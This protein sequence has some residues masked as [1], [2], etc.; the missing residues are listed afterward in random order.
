MAS[1]DTLISN[2]QTFAQGANTAAVGALDQMR[3]DIGNVGFTSIGF[4][5]PVLPD[6]PVFP[7]LLVPPTLDTIA[8][9]LPPDPAAAPVFQ[10][11]GAFDAGVAP[12]LTALVPVLTL[13]SKPADVAAFT[14]SLPGLTTSF[15]FPSAPNLDANSIPVP[16]IA[17]RAVPV[18]PQIVLPVFEAQRPGDLAPAPTDYN[19]QFIAAYQSAQPN[20]VASIEGYLDGVINRFNPNYRAAMT[21]IEAQL[22]KYLAGGTA[23]NPDIENAIYERSRGKGNAEYM[24]TRQVAMDDAARRGYTLPDGVL[25]ATVNAARQSAADNNAMSARDIAVAQAEMEQKNLQFA[26]STSADLRRSVL[27]ASLAYHSNLIQINGQA[28]DY[29]SKILGAIVQIY[30]SAV[31]AYMARADVYRAEATVYEVRLKSALAGIDLYR[32]QIDA[33]VALTRV[34]QSKIDVYK[35]RI[36]VLQSLAAVYRSQIDAVVAQASIEKL[37][38]DIFQAQVQGYA[39]T[40]GAKQAE[41]QGYTAAIGGEQAKQAVFSEQVRAFSANVEAYRSIVAAK[42]AAVSAAATTN[43]ARSRAYSAILSGYAAVVQARGDKARTQLENQRQQVIAFQ[44]T[45]SAQ[46]ANS[47]LQS[48]WYRSVAQIVIEN[49]KLGVQVVVEGAKLNLE[50]SKSTAA[51]GTAAAQVYSAVASSALSGINTLVSQSLTQ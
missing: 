40:V 3:H 41:Y 33:L 15:N 44:A 12:T 9:D 14:A 25:N 7:K 5:Q 28:I 18:A 10:D 30:D 16:V 39:A 1:V 23:L 42:S 13:P 22:A 4:N 37:K 31:K 27:S 32:A 50:Q 38:V 49:S 6:K 24:R 48:D 35:A 29:A 11:V 34:D 26:V 2:A 17:D 21:A 19:T 8:L 46:E 43:E 45:A 36:D 51:I 47:K 20:M